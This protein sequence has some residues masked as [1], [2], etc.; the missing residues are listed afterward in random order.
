MTNTVTHMVLTLP[1]VVTGLHKLMLYAVDGVA[2]GGSQ[3]QSHFA[4]DPAQGRSRVDRAQG[5][6][7]GTQLV[8][9]AGH[10]QLSEEERFQVEPRLLAAWLA[11]EISTSMRG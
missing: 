9:R 3:L 5:V 8:Q 4:L 11:D 6:L 10:P 7:V 2:L 1:A